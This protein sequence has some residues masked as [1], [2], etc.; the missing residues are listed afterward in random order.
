MLDDPQYGHPC[1][2]INGGVMSLEHLAYL[3]E[4]VGVVLVIAS[5]IYVGKQLRQNTDV[6]RL[7]AAGSYVNLQ[8]RLCGEVANNRE[9]A[10]YWLKG[11]SEFD[12]LD[13]V[14]K[15][16]VLLFEWRA[17]TAWN[18]LFQLRQD[19]LMP[20]SQWNELLWAIRNF[21][22][23]QSAREAWQVFKDAFGRPFQDFVSEYMG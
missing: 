17:I 15:Q 12:S 10:E 2:F 3:S 19:G 18:Q 22:R 8:E 16:R 11:A 5:L 7:N 9:L 14:D 21:G 4:I 13:E 23:R 20:E 6:M 1:V